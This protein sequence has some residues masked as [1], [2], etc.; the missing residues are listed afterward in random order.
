MQDNTLLRKAVFFVAI[1]NL[2]YFIIEFTVALNIGSVSIFADSI[3]F[4][5]D[6]SINLL[7][8]F[9][10]GLTAIRGAK[11]AMVLAAI[12]LIPGLATLWAVWQQIIG[13][14]PPAPLGLSFVGF[15]ALIVNCGCAFLLAQFRNYSGSLTRAA[16]L[17]ARNDAA[18]NIAIIFTGFALIIYPSIWPDIIVGLSIAAMNAGASFDVY[19]AARQEHFLAQ[20]D[21]MEG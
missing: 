16:F 8:F 20:K 3:D 1:A 12:M 14:Q 17:S 4:L 11:I 21:F 6:A 18:A 13:Q 7:I 9:A 10:I 15:G 19:Q 5:E 2:L